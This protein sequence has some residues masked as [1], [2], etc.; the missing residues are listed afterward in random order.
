MEDVARESIPA[1]L[2]AIED[3][4]IG[5]QYYAMKS[6][7]RLGIANE[8][9]I[10]ALVAKLADTNNP[11]IIIAAAQL[12]NSIEIKRLELALDPIPWEKCKRYAAFAKSI[13]LSVR[14]KGIQ[15]L[16]FYPAE[17]QEFKNALSIFLSDSNAWG[18]RTNQMFPEK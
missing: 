2:R 15:Y 9:I 17:S 8:S 11:V 13:V 18:A 7:V 6:L 10:P 5:V 12:L 14:V 16:R 1:L 4:H 3:G